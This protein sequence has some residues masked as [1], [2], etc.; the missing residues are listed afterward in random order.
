MAVTSAE[1]E[2]CM[3]R[4]ELSGV[5]PVSMAVTSAEVERSF[6]RASVFDNPMCLW[7]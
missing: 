2:R 6:I 1:V 3:A 4:P 7:P 5:I